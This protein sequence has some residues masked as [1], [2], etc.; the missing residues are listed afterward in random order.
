MDLKSFPHR[1]DRKN[2]Q[3]CAIIETPKNRRCKFDYDSES[4][5]FKLA[6][7]LPEGMMFPF[8]FGFIPSTLGGDGDPLDV[9]V[10]L[11]EP[12]HVGCL[13]DV[14]IIGVIQASQTQDGKTETND[15]LLAVSIHSYSH[16]KVSSVEDLNP[17]MLNQIEQFFVSY[18]KLRGKKFNLKSQGGPK[19]AVAVIEEGIQAFKKDSAR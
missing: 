14:R 1:L 15:R 3:C 7:M 12:T 4:N 17:S 5:L 13:L 18:N 16:E 10:L 8:D 2:R 11:E 9:L 19:R 6:G